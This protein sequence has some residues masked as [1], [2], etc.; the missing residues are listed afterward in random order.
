MTILISHGGLPFRSTE[1]KS[2]EKIKNI[3]ILEHPYNIY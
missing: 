1:S 3:Y 2:N